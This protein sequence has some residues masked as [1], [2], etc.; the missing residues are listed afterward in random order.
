MIHCQRLQT[1]QTAGI[2]KTSN[3]RPC[4]IEIDADM[5]RLYVATREG[6]ILIFDVK[7]LKQPY[8][9]HAVRV[10]KQPRSSR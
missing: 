7:D 4:A 8:M 10:L 3:A 6:M 9:V 2:I 1:N 5:E